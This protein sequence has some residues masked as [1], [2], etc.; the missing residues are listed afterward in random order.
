MTRTI[1]LV[2]SCG[3]A[4]TLACGSPARGRLR[5]PVAGPG[6]VDAAAVGIY[7][8]RFESG[9]GDARRFRLMLFAAPPDR[10]HGEVLGPL[11]SPQIIVDGGGGRLA[12]TV[13]AE[14]VAYVGETRPED[15]ARILGIAVSL[16]DFVRAVLDGQTADSRHSVVRSADRAGTLPADLELRSA[17]KLLRIEL[18]KRRILDSPAG[19]L[20]TGEPPAGMERRPLEQ[21]S[22]EGDA[23]LFAGAD[24][25]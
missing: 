21:W 17:D 1:L 25:P 13:V 6:E 10:L 24:A 16:E 14:R 20:G 9:S 23:G 18:L 11:G 7:R 4:L 2:A 3:L 22:G 5:A 12:L 19:P 15:V 8:G